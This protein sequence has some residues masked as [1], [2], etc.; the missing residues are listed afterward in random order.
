MDKTLYKKIIC[1][2]LLLVSILYERPASAFTMVDTENVSINAI[3]GSPSSGGISG[4]GIGI[5]QTSVR[6]SGEAYPHATVTVLK[7][8]KEITS[9]PADDKGYFTITLPETYKANVLYSLFAKDILGQ[10]SLLI[11][12]PIVVYPGYLTHLSGIRF[13][14]TVVTDKAQV[15]IGDYL[16]VSGYALPEAD[17]EI[18][19]ESQITGEKKIFT[20]ISQTTGAYNISIPMGELARGD[21]S[22]YV[23]YKGDTRISKLLKFVIGDTNILNTDAIVSIP[24]DCNRD[25][26]INLIDFSVLAFWYG[27]SSPPSCVDTNKDS[28]IN[29]VDFSILAFYWT[30]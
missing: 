24:G 20:L 25:K 13:A 29:L 9:V 4:G 2:I 17:L 5:P 21:Y 26:V 30:G 1:L 18:G 12:Y 27:K 28:I 19:M 22:V 15:K 7:E 16:G 14:P 11:N 3:V 6:F 10:R 8:G 23:K